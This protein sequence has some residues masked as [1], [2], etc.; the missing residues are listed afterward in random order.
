MHLADKHSKYA[1]EYI[2]ESQPLSWT[3]LLDTTQ[4]SKMHLHLKLADFGAGTYPF[5]H[6][7]SP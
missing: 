1:P 4:P 3:S 5:T 7:S 2:I 6:K